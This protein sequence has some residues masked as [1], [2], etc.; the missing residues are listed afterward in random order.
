MKGRFY[1]VLLGFSFLCITASTS[2]GGQMVSEKDKAWARL[3]VRQEKSFKQDSG[4]KTLAVLYFHNKTGWPKLDLLQKGMSIMLTT[5]LSKV[6]EIQLVERV[7][8]QALVTELGFGVSGL[9]ARD[10]APR[11]GRLLGATLVVGGN[12]VKE[13]ADSFK[14]ES[15][16]LTVPTEAM[17]GEPAV[18]GKLLAELFRM[19]KDLLFEII[20]LLK[21]ELSPDLRAEL[22]EPLTDSIDALIHFLE[23]VEKSDQKDYDGAI[24]SYKRA[25]ADDPG[26]EM[27]IAGVRELYDDRRNDRDTASDAI[28]EIKKEL[29]KK[30]CP[31]G[32]SRILKLRPRFRGP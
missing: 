23:A 5:D 19:E 30:A 11:M 13:D 26:L 17:L 15:G 22:K 10:K 25:L 14:L 27:A 21:L 2:W 24:E 8:I 6:K 7:K 28:N 32:R 16:L 12:I 9:V 20:R 31:A 4:L 1:M 18:Q 3:A 29:S